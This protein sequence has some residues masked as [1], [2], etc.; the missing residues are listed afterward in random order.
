MYE[1]KRI[2][3]QQIK[4]GFRNDLHPNSRFKP[5]NL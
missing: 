2:N 1:T 3:P 4:H 5:P